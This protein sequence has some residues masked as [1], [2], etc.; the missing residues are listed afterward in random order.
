MQDNKNRLIS[1]VIPCYN[2]VEYIEQSVD[3]ALKQTYPN[4]EVIVV[5]DGS[6]DKTKAV[7][8]HLEP[9]IT[10]LVTQDNHGQSTARNVGIK[11]AKGDFIVTLDSDDFFE[12]TFCEKAVDIIS[13]KKDVKIVTCH[14]NLLFKNK[15]SC[16]FK[17]PGGSISNFM[18]QSDALGTCMFKKE[19]WLFSGGYDESMKTGFED[20]EFFIRLLKEGGTVEVI[21]EA[22]YNYRKRKDSTSAKARQVKY[23]L[24]RYILNKHKELYIAGF[25][26]F[27]DEMLFKIQREEAE[28]I[29]NTERLEFKIGKAVLKPFRF[30]KSFFNK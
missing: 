6:N 4:I 28:K 12:P 14:A 2:D 23:D 13:N 19:D 15:P 10:K 16:V 30:V 24:W 22:L 1:F 9:R 5:D 27:V 18:Y 21:D 26:V 3:S 20:W 8:K 25:N 7:L 29:K 17:S 11:A